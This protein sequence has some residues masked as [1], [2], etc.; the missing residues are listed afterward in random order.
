MPETP[1]VRLDDDPIS[2]LDSGS[3]W[4]RY[5]ADLLYV[6]IDEH[7]REWIKKIDFPTV[8]FVRKHGLEY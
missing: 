3:E 1:T 4:G 7:G 6:S 8:S 5:I 2:I